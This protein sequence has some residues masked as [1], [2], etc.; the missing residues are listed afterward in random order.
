MAAFRNRQSFS[1]PDVLDIIDTQHQPLSV[2]HV[3]LNIINTL[4]VILIMADVNQP[5]TQLDAD[6]IHNKDWI[7]ITLNLMIV[8]LI[9]QEIDQIMLLI[10]ICAKFGEIF[11]LV[12]EVDDAYV[13]VLVEDFYVV[14]VGE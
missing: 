6:I 11:A 3:L 4:Q 14:W 9:F 12:L 8:L 2:L 7:I 5:R 1:F 13:E 10:E